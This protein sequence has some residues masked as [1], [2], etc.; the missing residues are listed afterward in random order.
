MNSRSH[1]LCAVFACISSFHCLFSARIVPGNTSGTES[2]TFALSTQA[3]NSSGSIVYVGALSQGAAKEYALSI[4]GFNRE[5]F[6]PFAPETVTL[7]NIVD[8][9]N[10]LYDAA[11]THLSILGKH[12]I[13]QTGSTLPIAVTGAD[14]ASLILALSDLNVVSVPEVK[15]AN[16]LTTEQIV[17]TE[18]YEDEAIFAAV[19]PANSSNF[20]Q[21]GSGIA[22]AQLQTE[23]VDDCAQTVLIQINA[24]PGSSATEPLA[25]ALDITSP[26]I[27]IGS[28]V[29]NISNAV[30]LWYSEH[31]KRLYVALQVQG[32]AGA[33]DGAR[34]VVVGRLID[35]KLSFSPIAPDAALTLQDKIVGGTGSNTQVS[36]LKVR[37]M[38]TTTGLDYL[39]VLGNVGSPAT[40]QN[41]V[42]A[43]PL[44]NLN[45]VANADPAVQGTLA[46]VT[47][48]P[49]DFFSHDTSDTCS[50]LPSLFVGRS[51]VVPAT[52]PNELFTDTSV[53]AIVG[54]TALPEGNITD[55][56]VSNDVVFVSVANPATNQLAGIFYAQ[57]LFDESGAI[58][59]WTPWQRVAGTTDAVY[60]FIYRATLGSFA[61]LTGQTNL[62]IMTV[63]ESVWG[64]GSPDGLGDL[65]TLLSDLFPEGSSGV[66]GFF[67][68]PLHTP[69][70][71]DI[72]AY[73]A[74]GFK[75]IALIQSG[76]IIA[77]TYT[78]T[79]GDFTSGL[80]QFTE[81]T[82]TQ[83]LPV[84]NS[85][86][87]AISGGVLD[88]IGPIVASAIGVNNLTNNGYLF[89][90]GAYGLAVLAQPD[91]TGWSTLNA[92]STD[93]AGLT[94]GMSFITLGNY[95][96]VRTLIFD[97]GFLYV[98]TDTQL[99]RIDVAASNFATGTLSVVTVATLAD[100]GC[101]ENGTLLDVAVSHSFALLASSNGLYRV[102]NG[103]D[104]QTAPD[105]VAV[106]WSEVV[107]PEGEQVVQQIQTIA[108]NSLP[109]G[110]AKTANGNVYILDAYMGLDTAQENRYT[111]QSVVAQPI[112]SNT[113]APLP[114]LKV[115]DI[116]T[117][118]NRFNMFVSLINF[119]GTDNFSARNRKLIANIAVRDEL[120]SVEPFVRNR[121]I[122]LPLG[123][124]DASLVSAITRSSASGAWMITGDFGLRVNE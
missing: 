118:F 24:Q 40:V 70:L 92:L 5:E 2:F 9:V 50:T 7:N 77:G 34:G 122:R 119:D 73:I 53:Q 46:D 21:P 4:W 110:F 63:K 84:G 29:I 85:R 76:S 93:F 87:V 54:I 69:G 20:G 123:I 101:P 55:I 58:A 6:S 41:Q 72:S 47:A 48:P 35:K 13:T 22:V 31:L 74:T 64:T 104:I 36:I 78:P 45:F 61:W 91:G 18:G 102:G 23:K 51:F 66:Q 16:G 115:K 28:N 90:G 57:A 62:S 19:T 33:T 109:N 14:P 75:K 113:I 71:F 12:K 98:L 121:D 106:E 15:D 68:L 107:V 111:V 80:V 59:A 96:F 56:N 30:D 52:Q 65:V 112:D 37:T 44:V 3:H 103:A 94:A 114:D 8:Q 95:C 108:S 10:P 88:N 99:D 67:D 81:G 25:S 86:V 26:S 83:N 79:T 60:S 43:M 105:N 27:A 97:E 117:A 89:V 116:L 17:A 100:I 39:I 82:V 32:A 11:I 1:R 49:M 124:E 38:R 42:Y 120:F